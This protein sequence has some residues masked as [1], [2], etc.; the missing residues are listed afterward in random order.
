VLGGWA[1]IYACTHTQTT[2]VL[3]VSPGVG[4]TPEEP[5][6]SRSEKV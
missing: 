4:R 5:E 3:G 2:L 1:L 6:E